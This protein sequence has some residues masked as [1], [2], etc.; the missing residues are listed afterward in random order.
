[1]SLKR[2][3]I[4]SPNYSSRGGTAVRLIVVHT[5][6]GART[7]QELGNFFASS[8]S[9]VSSQTGIDDT[10]GTIGEYVKR[11]DK[12]WTQANANPYCTSTELCAFAAWTPKDWDQH[13]TMLE[14]CARW[15]AE[16]AAHF[17]IPIRKLNASQAQGGS[18]GVCGHVDLGAA[19]GGHW[20][21]G[22]DFPWSKVIEMAK[23]G[24]GMPEPKP[25]E[26][27]PGA[28]WPA[29]LI[30]AL[31]DSEGGLVPPEYFIKDAS[32][33]SASPGS[34]YAVWPSGL[35]RKVSPEERDFLKNELTDGIPTFQSHEDDPGTRL[36]RMDQALRGMLE[37]R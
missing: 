9:A 13:P 17:G 16:E 3:W 34:T 24:G 30:A 25:P 12:A 4:R 27:E 8:S 26:E 33:K 36:Y 7:Y 5:A 10:P 18:A 6:E 1:V 32:K 22:P 35:T 15:I 31:H 11:P 2:V 19:G 28:A 21:P 29:P 23:S 37:K 20:D 14:N